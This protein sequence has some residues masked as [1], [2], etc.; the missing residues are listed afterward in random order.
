MF[1]SIHVPASTVAKIAR[2]VQW[3]V[4]SSSVVLAAVLFS[5]R[6]VGARASIEDVGDAVGKVS[7]VAAAAQASAFHAESVG[8]AHAIELKQLWLHTIAMQA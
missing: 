5:Y 6:W 3:L 8:N 7:V 2:V 4:P 1:E